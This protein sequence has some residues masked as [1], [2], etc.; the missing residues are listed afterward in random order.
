MA[1]LEAELG[2]LPA[3]KRELTAEVAALDA[4]IRT[5]EPKVRTPSLSEGL[6]AYLDMRSLQGSLKSLKEKR[7][8]QAGAL[9][10]LGGRA[11][12]LKAELQAAK[13]SYRDES[14]EAM[15]RLRARRLA[16]D[17]SVA[18]QM[19]DVTLALDELEAVEQLVEQAAQ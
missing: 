3:T 2:A 17:E 8:A 15:G 14:S 19:Y 10:A 7:S 16:F 6:G 1:S 9:A 12:D 5:T 18:E 11:A 13:R 4:Q